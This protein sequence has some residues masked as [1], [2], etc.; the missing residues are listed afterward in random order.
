MSPPA[1]RADASLVVTCSRNNSVPFKQHTIPQGSGAYVKDAEG[2]EICT[3]QRDVFLGVESRSRWGS[4]VEHMPALKLW[5]QD[6]RRKGFLR[7]PSGCSRQRSLAGR[8]QRKLERPAP[9]RMSPATSAALEK[10]SIYL[11]LN[12]RQTVEMCL[13]ITSLPE[14]LRGT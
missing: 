2:W 3:C 8:S 5:A 9:K 14:R 13:S 6:P 4:L 7:K 11:E 12:C 10:G 1:E